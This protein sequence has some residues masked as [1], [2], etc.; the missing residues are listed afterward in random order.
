MKRA[1]ARSGFTILEVLV[2]M[3]ILLFGM[4]TILGLLTYGTALSRTAQLRTSAASAAQATIADLEETFFP[5]VAGEAGEPREIVDRAV[6]GAEGLVYSAKGRPNPDRP[7]EYRVDIAMTW[8]SQGVK[9]EKRFTTLL[10]RE[11]QFGERLRHR[12]SP[13]PSRTESSTKPAAPPPGSGA[14]P[15]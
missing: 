8:S 15:R 3:A 5:D 11:L 6:P 13:G 1:H 2:A 9:R 14:K 12:A 7:L 10:Q 4:T